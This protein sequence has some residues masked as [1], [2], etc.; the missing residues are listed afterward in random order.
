MKQGTN[1]FEY[2]LI[3]R[4]KHNLIV[5]NQ[6]KPGFKQTGPAPVAY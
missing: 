6:V 2:T 4:R 3:V 5:N 1:K